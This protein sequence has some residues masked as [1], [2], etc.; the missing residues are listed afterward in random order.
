MHI[1][2]FNEKGG[3][4]FEGD[5]GAYGGVWRENEKGRNIMIIP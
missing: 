4:G 2:T 5:Q 1:R 3:N